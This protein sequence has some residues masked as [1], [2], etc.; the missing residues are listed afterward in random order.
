MV[1]A[2]KS[3][4]KFV[5]VQSAE[6]YYY[7]APGEPTYEPISEHRIETIIRDHYVPLYGIFDASEIENIKKV[8]KLSVEEEVD[9]PDRSLI[10]IGGGTYWDSIKHG[11]TKHPNRPCFYRLFN[12]RMGTKHVVV[13]EPFTEAQESHMWEKYN[14]VLYSLNTGNDLPMEYDFIKVWAN[15]NVELYR[16]MMRAIAACFLK[17]KPLGSYVLVGEGRNGKS[18]FIGLL[19]TIFGGN[20]TS[21][22]QLTQLGDP[23]HT[24][25]LLM[26]L[27]NAPDEEEDKA[28]LEQAFF[29]TM[30]DHGQLKLPVMRSNVPVT[31]SCDFMSFF[32]M[33]H[34]PEWKGTGAAACI[35]RTLVIPF[36]ADLSANDT[37]QANFAETTY[38]SEM[39]CDFMGTVFALASYYSEHEMVFSE[40]MKM[41]QDSLMDEADSCI[42]FKKL[43]EKYFDG[44]QTDKQLYNEYAA[45]CIENSLPMKTLKELKF[46]FRHYKRSSTRIQREGER[47]RVYTVHQPNHHLFLEDEYLPEFKRTVGDFLEG[48]HSVVAAII[49]FYEDQGVNLS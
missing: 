25:E 40:A 15:G 22:V 38:T 19:H 7:Q 42:V 33:N 17:K 4:F 13:V 48:Q 35:K 23:H 9:E 34:I 29:K 5:Y 49:N 12:T 46:V 11:L 37:D 6:C 30:S 47:R 28:L 26:T 32:P 16:D 45:W 31:L 8:L 20:N 21:M 14:Q 41:E 43:W 36:D 44:F 3:N 2:I 39:L 18:T 10:Y 1:A 27:L 24:H